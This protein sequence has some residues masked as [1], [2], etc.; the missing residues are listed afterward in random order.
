MPAHWWACVIIFKFDGQLWI[1]EHRAT[2]FGATS[3][4]H[5]WERV[6]ALVCTIARR[7]LKLPVH[8]YVDDYLGFERST[9]VKHSM[10]CF[11]RLV[12]L[13]LGHGA[14][15]DRKLECGPSLTI[16]GVDVEM[17]MSGY[18]CRPANGKAQKCITVMNKALAE[19]PDDELE[20]LIAEKIKEMCYVM[21]IW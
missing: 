19:M 13:L 10:E 8:R 3:S 18:R 17:D 20:D 7:A 15:A 14:V 11:A 16:L 9:L 1:S 12:R 5:A 2:P 6:G 4:V 21:K